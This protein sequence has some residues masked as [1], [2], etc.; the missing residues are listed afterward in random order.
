MPSTSR[1]LAVDIGT[2]LGWAYSSDGKI[3]NWGVEVF[4][5][6][7]EDPHGQG[8]RL[9]KFWNWLTDWN[10]VHEVYFEEVHHGHHQGNQA[11][12]TYFGML[13]ILRMFCAGAN[14]PLI[15]R[16]TGTLK[17]DFTGNGRAEKEDMCA[18]A[19]RMGWR[20]GEKGT[21]FDHDACDACALI[22]TIQRER[23]NFI[24]F[25]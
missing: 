4:P 25:F 15:G 7:S 19:H 11:A 9:L 6:K 2:T 5:S 16:H 21:A 13:G 22:V 3:K 17:R 24:E 23:N 18:Q 14:I 1:I 8:R 12:A 10:G 20:G